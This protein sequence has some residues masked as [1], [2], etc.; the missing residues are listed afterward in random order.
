MSP[1]EIFTL[2]VAHYTAQQREVD[3]TGAECEKRN[4]PTSVAWPTSG[5]CAGF[6][7]ALWIM[8]AFCIHVRSL[9]YIRTLSLWIVL[10]TS[11]TAVC[12]Q[13]SGW[14][15][16]ITRSLHDMACSGMACYR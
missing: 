16:L 12:M 4:T 10:W 2:V 11:K 13:R 14:A 3:E 6:V 7:G 8:E 5:I 15:H 1:V 9:V